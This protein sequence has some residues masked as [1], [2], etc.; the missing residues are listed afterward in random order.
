[1]IHS[2]LELVGMDEAAK[3]T[4]LSISTLYDYE[5][6]GKFPKRIKIANKKRLAIFDKSEIE[7]WYR[8]F[9][10]VVKKYDDKY[11]VEKRRMMDEI[12]G[13]LLAA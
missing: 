7:V 1:M 4:N 5:R 11:E 13:N 12:I 3:L 6:A 9:Y 2:N 8:D 10:L